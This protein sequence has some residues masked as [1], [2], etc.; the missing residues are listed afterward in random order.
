M[1]AT[2]GSALLQSSFAG[3]H[4]LVQGAP[5]PAS[6]SR[7][8]PPQTA[9]ATAATTAATATGE[10]GQADETE[11]L[12]LQQQQ[13]RKQQRLPK[14]GEKQQGSSRSLVTV[15]RQIEGGGDTYERQRGFLVAVEAGHA[16]VKGILHAQVPK[17]HYSQLAS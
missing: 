7:G 9:A 6:A 5:I 11:L 12:L 13:Q 10:E 2:K 8:P 16:T 15:K 1:E 14:E 4:P 17:Y 3:F